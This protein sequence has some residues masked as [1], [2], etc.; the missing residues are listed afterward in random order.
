MSLQP[1]KKLSIAKKGIFYNLS[2]ASFQLAWRQT[3][4]KRGIS[5]YNGWLMKTPDEI[6]TLRRVDS[7]LATYGTVNLSQQAGRY[8]DKADT[9]QQSCSHKPDKVTY[10][11][12]P[13]GN[14]NCLS[15]NAPCQNIGHQTLITVK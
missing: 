4:Q 2:I 5:K 15:V 6:L 9:A 13:K 7:G 3:V 12:A 10:H 1:V 8:L 14:K 11:P